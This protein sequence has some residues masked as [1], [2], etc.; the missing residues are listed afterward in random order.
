MEHFQRMRTLGCS[1]NTDTWGRAKM[2]FQ[3]ATEP[4]P[5][6]LTLALLEKMKRMQD[7]EKETRSS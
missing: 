2:C 5:A 4:T 1:R 3:R 6:F 7:C